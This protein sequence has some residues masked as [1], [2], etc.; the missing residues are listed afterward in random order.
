M[1]SYKGRPLGSMGAMAAISFH[2]TKNLISGEGGALIVNDPQLVAR[3]EIA[4]EK[5]TN[6]AALFRGEV[7]KYTW[8]ALGSSY[9]PS[10]MTAAFLWAQLEQADE[11]TAQRV[12][13]WQLYHALF[14][15]AEARGLLQRPVVPAWSVHN[16]HVFYV[17][18][19]SAEER[20]KVIASLRARGIQAVFH[21]VP[22]HSS[23]AGRKY[24]RAHGP[25]AVTDS[26]SER[27]LRL[28]MFISL[29]DDEVRE[30]AEAVVEALE[31]P[32]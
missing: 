28:P 19:R 14:A 24:G 10:E 11:L 23:P 17:I 25:L 18:L 8:V 7:D 4:W 30:V 6:R 12:H 20:A 26:V 22:L 2:E 3:A 16:G 29:R 5:G 27:L 1:A 13:L 21:Y 15:G 31:P 32:P 9:L